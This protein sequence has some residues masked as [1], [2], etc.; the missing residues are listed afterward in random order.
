ME[1]PCKSRNRLL[2][3]SRATV[4]TPPLAFK[5][6]SRELYSSSLILWFCFCE[7]FS[8]L[9]TRD[10]ISVL[11]PNTLNGKRDNHKHSH[12]DLPRHTG[13][14]NDSRCNRNEY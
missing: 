6:G 7:K 13:N 14:L 5:A 4:P 10:R 2:Q 12:P 3:S 8:L 1:D 9:L 11:W